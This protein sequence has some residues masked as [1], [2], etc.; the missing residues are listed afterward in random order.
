MSRP[1]ARPASPALVARGVAF[2]VLAAAAFVL[3]WS[4]VHTGFLA[5]AV[6]GWAMSFTIIRLYRLGAGR[7]SRP[8]AAFLVLL[9][10]G[11]VVVA[12]FAALGHELIGQ[13]AVTEGLDAWPLRWSADVWTRV[14]IPSLLDPGNAVRVWGEGIPLAVFAV[15]GAVQTF[16]WL[17]RSALRR[18]RLSDPIA[19]GP[20][21]PDDM[22]TIAEFGEP[23]HRASL[24]GRKDLTP[25]ALAVLRS[26]H[27]DEVQRALPRP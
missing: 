24:A 4:V 15:L 2:A 1:P 26:D 14:A 13:E 3:L 6:I 16:W 10:A 20:M 11:T 12:D 5:F 22:L 19:F 25:E 17:G 23:G 9:I 7:V 27:S 18:R 21:S 8:A